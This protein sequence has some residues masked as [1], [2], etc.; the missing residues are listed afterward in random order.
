MD[1]ISPYP[2]RD[3]WPVI[4]EG[5]ESPR[6]W[7]SWFEE[8]RARINELVANASSTTG[9]LWSSV[10]KSGSN[11]T[12]L[13]TRNHSDLQNI[14]SATYTHLTKVQADDLTDAGDSSLHYHLSDRIY[15]R[16]SSIG[17]V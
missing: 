4:N 14:N 13:E 2:S 7:N 6:Q 17:R 8:V 15:A 5:A 10:N 1:K 16:N 9:T 12:D 3:K 11:L